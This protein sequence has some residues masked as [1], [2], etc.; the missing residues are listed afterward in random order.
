MSAIVFYFQL[1]QP[2]QLR[3]Y[4][5]FDLGVN[6]MYEDTESNRSLLRM[7]ANNAY[8]PMNE[9]L[10]SL[11]KKY[12]DRFNVSFSISGTTL[13][14]FADYAPDVLESFK[15]LAKTQNVEFIDET[16]SHSLA[17]LYSREEFSQQVLHHKER[18]QSLLGVSPVTFRNT[19]LVY[20]NDLAAW[21]EDMGYE[22]ILAEGA[23]HLLGWRSPN[24]IYQPV[25]CHKVRLLLRNHT[26]SDDIAIRFADRSW[27]GFPLT[28]ETYAEWLH[29]LSPGAEVINLFMDYETFGTHYAADTGIFDF[30]RTLPGAVLK[31]ADFS[32]LTPSQAVKQY[33]PM[34]KIDAPQYISWTDAERDLTAWLGNDMQ[35]DAIEALYKLE[36]NV[37]AVDSP[38]LYQV[39]QRLQSSDHF[40]YMS[41]KWLSDR[42]VHPTVNPYASPYDA[43]INYMNVLADFEGTLTARLADK[44][45]EDVKTPVA[46]TVGSSEKV[47]AKQKAVTTLKKDKAKTGRKP[48]KTAEQ[49]E[50]VAKK[51]K[52]SV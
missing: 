33:P 40:Y 42:E 8:L 52:K 28:A 20:N 26:L 41:T 38:E 46:K 10:L 31:R 1:H 19:E 5:V 9:L 6:H 23:D 15:K 45:A 22:A 17:F 44:P 50:P 7:L 18:M 32:F 47:A 37:R 48:A 29:S 25:N 27:P 13:E 36:D 16:Y 34:A 30:M 2:F 14:Q 24:Y 43:Y 3:P 49:P 12:K 35:L 11:I 4:T 39:W 51:A 21:I